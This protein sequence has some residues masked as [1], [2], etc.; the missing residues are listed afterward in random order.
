M[1]LQH[2]PEDHHNPLVRGNPP[3]LSSGTALEVPSPPSPTV[4]EDNGSGGLG[5][6]CVSQFPR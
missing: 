6:V 5:C 2:P 4:K 3:V 1:G